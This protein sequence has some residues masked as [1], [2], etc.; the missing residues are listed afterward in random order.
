MT[1]EPS[2]SAGDGLPGTAPPP[3]G[4]PLLTVLTYDEAAR[5]V[6]ALAEARFPVRY[7]SI[8]GHGVRTVDNVTG[9]WGPARAVASTTLAGGVVGLLFGLLFDW[10]R[11][12]DTDVGW[13]WLAFYGLVYAA[14]A[15][16]I[17]SLLF[18]RVGQHDLSSVRAIDAESYDV[19]LNGGERAE[20]MRILHGGG[21]V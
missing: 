12:A 9:R 11:A 8:V 3:D 18:A 7:V 10:W 5:A 21:I 17:V 15:G 4:R 13:A 1:T 14:L 6:D 16:L 20:A 19:T 2:D